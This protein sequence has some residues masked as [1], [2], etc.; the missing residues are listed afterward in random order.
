[1]PVPIFFLE[2]AASG[3]E[4]KIFLYLIGIFTD[5]SQ[6]G[7]ESGTTFKLGMIDEDTGIYKRYEGGTHTLNGE[8][9]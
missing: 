5:D 4:C 2:S 8:E 6:G 7:S 3:R 1:M 9:L